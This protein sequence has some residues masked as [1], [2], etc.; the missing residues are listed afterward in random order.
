MKQTMSWLVGGVGGFLLVATC[1]SAQTGPTGTTSAAPVTRQVSG[2][3]QKVEGFALVVKMLPDGDVRTFQAQPGR[4]ATIDGQTVTLDKVVPG[5]VL[6]AMVTWVP[7]PGTATTVTGD[8]VWVIK[9]SAVTVKLADGSVKQYTVK[10]D[11][12]FTLDGR[13]AKIEDLRPGIKLTAVKLTE[14]PATKITPDTPITGKAPK[15]KN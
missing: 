2:E 6:T 8:V 4:T 15:A 14:D 7:A 11:F 12:E 5:T 9:P 1:A 13:Q 10:D 3:V